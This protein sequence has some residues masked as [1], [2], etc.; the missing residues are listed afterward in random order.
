[1]IETF[2]AVFRLLLDRE[3]D[4]PPFSVTIPNGG[5]S[6]LAGAGG[7]VTVSAEASGNTVTL[8]VTSGGETVADIP[9]GVTLTVPAEDTAPG[10]VAVLVNADGS[11]EVIRKSVAGEST[12]II[13]LEGSAT[14]EILDNSRD[15]ADVAADSWYSGAVA[16]ASGHEL[17]NGTSDTTFTPDAP[18]TRGML[19]QVLH[20]LESNPDALGGSAFAD[21]QSGAWYAEAV[22]WASREG[23][24]T[25][26]GGGAFGPDD[27][28]TREQLAVMLYRYAGAMGYDTAQGGTA[29]WAYADYS[30]VSA[31]AWEAMN[32]AV[33]SGI[34]RG[35]AAGILSPGTNA[36]RVAAAAMLQRFCQCYGA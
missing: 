12:V 21:V 36:G 9:G 11:R 34:I 18:M 4:L 17:F 8:E 13:P 16:F 29:L 19:A 2:Q 24:V 5:L 14:V 25:G 26:Y 15:F 31:Y 30:Q 22:A 35:T 33:E 7:A 20:N 23:I 10:T 6:D 28:I 27:S 3:I 32:W 1:M